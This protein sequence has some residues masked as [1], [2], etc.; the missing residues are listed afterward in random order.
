MDLKTL[1]SVKNHNWQSSKYFKSLEIFLIKLF[2]SAHKMSKLLYSGTYY[3]GQRILSKAYF[4][5]L[6]KLLKFNLQWSS[7]FPFCELQIHCMGLFSI[8]NCNNLVI[9]QFRKLWFI[10]WFI[11]YI[12]EQS[13]AHHLGQSIEEWIK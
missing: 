7:Q 10:L 8:C 12:V 3:K 1:Q 13:L 4:V 11:I 9:D 6:K 5:C 2:W